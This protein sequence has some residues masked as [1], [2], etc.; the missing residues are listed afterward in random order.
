MSQPLDLFAGGPPLLWRGV[1]FVLMD[2]RVPRC[3]LLARVQSF[4]EVLS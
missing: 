1:E 4:R 2:G 3:G